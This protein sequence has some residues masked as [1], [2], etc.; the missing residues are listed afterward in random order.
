MAIRTAPVPAVYMFM[1]WRQSGGVDSAMIVSGAFK[2][3]LNK[4][5]NAFASRC[6]AVRTFRAF[7]VL[8]TIQGSMSKSRWFANEC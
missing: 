6:A 1:V 3:F 2:L 8:V 5:W 4:L 7:S